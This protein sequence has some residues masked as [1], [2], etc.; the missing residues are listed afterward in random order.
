MTSAARVTVDDFTKDQSD[1]SDQWSP[2]QQGPVAAWP[3]GA[4]QQD[5]RLNAGATAKF[6]R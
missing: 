1:C 5:D 3:V 6:R 4:G 2:E